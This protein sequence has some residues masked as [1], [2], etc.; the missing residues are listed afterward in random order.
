MTFSICH[1]ELAKNP[2]LL[3]Q[4]YTNPDSSQAQ[5]DKKQMINV[6]IKI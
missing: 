3:R 2:K 6:S 4:N 1:S 5:N